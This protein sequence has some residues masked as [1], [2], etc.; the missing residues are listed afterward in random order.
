MDDGS[1]APSGAMLSSTT[2]VRLLLDWDDDT[3]RLLDLLLIRL[4]TQ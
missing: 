3:T 1:A 4:G 2:G